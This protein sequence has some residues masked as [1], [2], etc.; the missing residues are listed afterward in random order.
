MYECGRKS[1]RQSVDTR[2]KRSTVDGY[3]Q[4]ARGACLR[5]HERDQAMSGVAAGGV[6]SGG[7]LSES[8]IHTVSIALTVGK[9]NNQRAVG[10]AVHRRRQRS[11]EDDPVLYTLELFDFLDNE[12][13]SNLDSFLVQMGPCVLYVSDEHED[14]HRGDGKKLHLLCESKDI[15]KVLVKRSLFA[16]KGGAA[17]LAKLCVQDAL[18]KT[19]SHAVNVAEAERPL[20]HSCIDVLV[21]SLRLLD[22]SNNNEEASGSSS[23]SG[24]GHLGHYELR[25]GALDAHMTLDSAA[26]EAVNLLPKPDHPSQFGS[27]YGVLNRCRT[28]MGSRLLDR[29]LRQPLVDATE[30]NARLDVVEIL[31]LNTSARTQLYDGGLKGVPDLDQVIAKMQKKTAGLAE[32]FKLYTFTRALPKVRVSAPGHTGGSVSPMNLVLI[33]PPAAGA[34]RAHGPRGHLRGAGPG[35]VA[36][37]VP[38]PVPVAVAGGG[39]GS[40]GRGHTG[41]GR[42][43]RRGAPQRPHAP[44]RAAGERGGQVRHVPAAGGTRA[45]PGPAAGPRREPAA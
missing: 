40:G 14:V 22:S 19:H 3:Q 42:A 24:G 39:R 34:R 37:A 10:A 26:A 27:I 31:K 5:A 11:G 38:V 18:N 9:R 2:S 25:L 35:L 28:K 8:E 15:E 43:T 32:V 13:L 45:G 23:S 1:G 41:P 16:K 29:W 4:Q 33:S 6:D 36:V 21:A 44:H 30:I 7:N 20:G 17:A 12:Q